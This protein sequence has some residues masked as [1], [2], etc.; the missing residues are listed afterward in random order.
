MGFV[1]F[2]CN[3]GILSHEMLDLFVLQFV[4]GHYVLCVH[5]IDREVCELWF[6]EFKFGFV[7][8]SREWLGLK[9]ICHVV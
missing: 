6:P 7:R 1:A 3:L 2:L 9:R 4:V 8:F 5:I